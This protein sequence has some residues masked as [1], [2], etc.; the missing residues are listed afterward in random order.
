MKTNSSSSKTHLPSEEEIQASQKWHLIDAE[1]MTLGRLASCVSKLLRGR[2][3][4]IYT[5]NMMTGDGVIITNAGKIKVT[6]RKLEQKMYYHHTGFMGGLK[7]EPLSSLLARRPDRVIR[8]AVKG[9]LPRNILARK[10]LTR[11]KIYTGTEHP[12]VAQKPEPY[13][14]GPK[15]L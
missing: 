7:V 2:H 10:M 14:F 8:R 12:H 6:G 15:E 5:P 1:G 13:K 11:L 9:M 4:A 3:K